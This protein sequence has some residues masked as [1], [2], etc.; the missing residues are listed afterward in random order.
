M[1]DP[2]FANLGAFTAPELAFVFGNHIAGLFGLA[3]GR[4]A[5]LSADDGVLGVDGGVGQSERGNRFAW[6]AYEMTTEPEIV[7]D[8]TQS[9]ETKL[10]Q[11]QCDFWDG[12]EQ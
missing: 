9:T 5:A 2:P 1:E 3:A 10:E 11:S 8:T 7:L 12:I 6:P 4:G